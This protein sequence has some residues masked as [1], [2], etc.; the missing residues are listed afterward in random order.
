VAELSNA[1]AEVVRREK[2]RVIAS[3]V[4]RLGSIDAAEEAFQEAVLAALPSWRGCQP[5]PG[6]G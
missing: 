4:R 2:S 1:I 5:T 6:R 3:L